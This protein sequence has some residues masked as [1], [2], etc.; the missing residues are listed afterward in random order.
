MKLQSVAIVQSVAYL[1]H[2]YSLLTPLT[3]V[4]AGNEYISQTKLTI[5][6]DLQ[7]QFI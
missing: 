3:C 4:R 7:L 1:Y 5:V 2:S 6:V